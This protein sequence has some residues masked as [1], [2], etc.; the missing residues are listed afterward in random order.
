MDFHV[1]SKLRSDAQLFYLYQGAQK[2]RGRRRKFAGR[3]DF[4]DLSGFEKIETNESKITL[5]TSAVWSVS[6]K[7]AVRVVIAVNNKDQEKPRY[8]V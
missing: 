6:L 1:I 3:V 5:Y 8:A 4:N 7:R 2:K